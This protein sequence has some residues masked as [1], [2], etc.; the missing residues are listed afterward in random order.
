MVGSGYLLNWWVNLNCLHTVCYHIEVFHI[1][2]TNADRTPFLQHHISWL[3]PGIIPS[4]LP[5]LVISVHHHSWTSP[6]CTSPLLPMSHYPLPMSTENTS[7]PAN[8]Q[9][10]YHYCHIQLVHYLS[11]QGLS[12]H[13]LYFLAQC[14]ILPLA[15]FSQY[16]TP[17]AQVQSVHCLMPWPIPITIPPILSMSKQYTPMSREYPNVYSP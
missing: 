6:V 16:T 1:Y 5:I 11:F 3:F 8:V 7:Y 9:F 2:S 12:V 17:P 13:H 4:L 15:M 14:T 10:E